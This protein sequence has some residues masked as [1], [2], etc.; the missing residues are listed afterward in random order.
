MENLIN[1]AVLDEPSGYE[2]I[3]LTGGG[4]QMPGLGEFIQEKLKTEVGYFKLPEGLSP[5]YDVIA[6]GAAL[7][8][9]PG[10]EKVNFKK[11]EQVNGKKS[12]IW[13]G[14]LLLIPLILFSMTVKMKEVQLDRE[15][16]QLIASM[17]K[18]IRKEFP[19]IGRVDAPV[20]QVKA[21]I[22]K[23][24]G[25]SGGTSRKVIP[26]L[27]DISLARQGLDLTLYEIDITDEAIKLKGESDSFQSVDQ[28][29]T[30]LA[31]K[32]DSVE[33]QES[34]TKPNKRIDFGIKIDFTKSGKSEKSGKEAKKDGE[35]SSTTTTE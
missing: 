8:D 28:F 11:D 26:M 12:L 7:Y 13:L 16:K 25:G 3:I 23:E 32:F 21:L 14:L 24:Q 10:Q 22:K 15:N 9:T 27:S 4:A 33:M 2:K 31:G 18:A 1:S 34:K 6:F 5:F 17:T 35:T 29:R 19:A 20:R 30:V